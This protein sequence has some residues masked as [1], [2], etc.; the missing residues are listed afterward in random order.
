MKPIPSTAEVLFFKSFD[1]LSNPKW[2]DWATDMLIAGFDTEHL[3]MLAAES[4]PL[5]AHK[6]SWL[7]DKVFEEL[8]IDFKDTEANIKRYVS[9]LISEAEAG[10]FK[11]LSVLERLKNLCVELVYTKSLFQFYLLYLAKWDLMDGEVQFYVNEADKDNIDTIIME[12]F[13][14][15]LEEN[16]L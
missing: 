9:Y 1:K 8:D 3:R 4:D 12:S 2:I 15:Y 14:K 6:I 10:K 7:T 13:R 16:P 11:V 5:D